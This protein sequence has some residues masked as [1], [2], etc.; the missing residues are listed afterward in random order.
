MKIKIGDICIFI[1]IV[2]VSVLL[3]I[4]NNEKGDKAVLYVDGKQIKTFDLNTNQ[5]Y[6]FSSDFTNTIS[7]VNGKVSILHSDCPDKTC[8]HSG[9][10]S[11]EGQIICCLPNKL[12]LKIE[13]KNNS[14]DVITG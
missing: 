12:M 5:E 10:I 4:D 8:V 11:K 2:V 9:Q 13:G 7:I 1:F 14:V 3:L 6:T